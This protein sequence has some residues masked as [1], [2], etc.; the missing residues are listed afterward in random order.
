MKDERLWA[1]KERGL[2]T[3]EQAKRLRELGFDEPC[4]S[5]YWDGTLMPFSSPVDYNKF[6]KTEHWDTI[7]APS[8]RIALRWANNKKGANSNGYNPDKLLDELEGKR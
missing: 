5:C 7:S 6:L 1:A 8:M 2:V 3:Y 4:C